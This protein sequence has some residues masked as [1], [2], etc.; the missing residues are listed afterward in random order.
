MKIYNSVGCTIEGITEKDFDKFKKV[1]WI[2]EEEFI[3]QHPEEFD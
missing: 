1:G 3:K 2:T